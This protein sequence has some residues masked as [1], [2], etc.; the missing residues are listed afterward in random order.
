MSEIDLKNLTIRKA[1]QSMEGGD[2]SAEDLTRAYLDNIK[3]K[4]AELNAYLR[5]FD[6]AI[7]EARK[8]DEKRKKGEKLGKLAGIPIAIKDVIMVKGS[9]IT[10]G[11]KILKGHIATYDATCVAKLRAEDAVFLGITNTD[12]FAMGSSTEN[13]AYG[14]SKNPIDSSRVPGGSSG[15]SASALAADMC[16]VALGTETGGSVRQ[17]A[18][19]CGLVGLKPSYGAVSRYGLLALCSSFD[20]VG[21]F[22]KSVEDSQTVFDIIAGEDSLDSTSVDY[23]AKRKTQNAKPKNKTKIGVPKLD[24]TGID[25]RVVENF[26]NQIKKAKELGFEV[27][28]VELPNIKYSIPTYYIILPAEA[29]ANLARYDGIR[30]GARVEGDNLLAEYVNSKG[31]GYGKEPRR[32]IILGTYVLSA[33]YYDAY[34]GTAM[35]VRELIKNDFDNAFKQVDAIIMPTTPGPAFKLG[36]KSLRSP[37][38]M[39]LEDIFT[40]PANI[41]GICG[42]SVPS[43]SVED[44]GKELPLGLQI[45]ADK[46][47][48]DICFEIGKRFVGELQ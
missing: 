23:N 38:E 29:S 3:S 45:I 12:E 34:Y 40:A 5:V 14:P 33:G 15:G 30:Y 28:E 20:Q 18:A 46:G 35:R 11:S 41:A 37:L 22:S 26:E 32:R 39:Y 48:E 21:I 8:I 2:Y 7:D 1:L 6:D 19:F 17:P 27:V 4:N 16:L 10:G 43:G 36:T 42:V 47:R 24:F 9:E 44:G 31:Q 13:S 25:K